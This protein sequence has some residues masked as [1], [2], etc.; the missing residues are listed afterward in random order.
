MHQK[1]QQGETIVLRPRPGRDTR[2]FAISISLA[3]GP[4]LIA[5]L[6]LTWGTDG[7]STVVGMGVALATV[8]LLVGMRLSRTEIRITPAL[9]TERDVFG[10]IHETPVAE[11]ASVR[12]VSVYSGRSLETHVQAFFLDAEGRTR[13]RMKGSHW[14]D[15]TTLRA[16][17][18]YGLP[19]EKIADPLPRA[20]LRHRFR[21]NLFLHERHP[22]IWA[23]IQALGVVGIGVPLLGLLTA[24][25]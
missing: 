18:A 7:F 24:V 21:S 22:V 20:E 13:L 10:R 16:S 25:S 6:A 15:R 11:I 4:P 1:L 17:A 2:S 8:S 19:V 9:L 3:L 23:G 5:L 12:V 14:G